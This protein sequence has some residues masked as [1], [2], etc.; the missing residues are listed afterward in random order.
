MS[1]NHCFSVSGS[2]STE[3]NE[4]FRI[5]WETQIIRKLLDIPKTPLPPIPKPDTGLSGDPQPIPAQP[6]LAEIV[7]MQQ[8]LIGDLMQAFLT[9]DKPAVESRMP[10]FIMEIKKEGIH[11]EAMKSVLEKLEKAAKILEEEIKLMESA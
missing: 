5:F 11:I 9:L 2:T 3:C 10:S 6:R 4:F 7:E 8:L 1:I